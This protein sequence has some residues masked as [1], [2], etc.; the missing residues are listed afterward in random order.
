MSKPI[1][2]S[3]SDII[4]MVAEE[5]YGGQILNNSYRGDVVEM[6]VLAA[7]GSNW[8]HVGLGWHPW[9]LQRGSG[10]D[11]IRIQV[12]QTAAIQVWGD[13]KARTL[14]FNWR[15]NP[16]SYFERDNPDEAIEVE[17]WF[18]D[19][20]VFGLHDETDSLI[21]DQADPMQWKFLVIPVCDL[22]KG[23]GS[24]QLS[25]ARNLWTAVSWNDLKLEVE[26]QAERGKLQLLEL[27]TEF[28]QL[29]GKIDWQGDL[30]L[31]R[32]DN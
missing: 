23:L 13:T 15:P 8:K 12:K 19:L 3:R 17:G 10:D 31:M 9:D 1:I 28:R 29:F 18:C 27:Q 25:K 30:D 24:M 5:I 32:L 16:P 21:A 7:L 22:K 11:R 14:R 26:A 4:D 6:M 2:P 20:F